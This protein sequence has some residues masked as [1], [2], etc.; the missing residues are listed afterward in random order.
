MSN[1]EAKIDKMESDIVSIKS[2][3]LDLG[4]TIKEIQ[5]NSK[6]SNNNNI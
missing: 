1:M 4:K 5:N 2:M 3:L 6:A